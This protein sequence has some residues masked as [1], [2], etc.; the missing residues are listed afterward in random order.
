M[1]AL[2]LGSI[3][4][5]SINV[6]NLEQ[7]LAFYELSLG[8]SRLARP[9]LSVE[10]AWLAVGSSELHLIVAVGSTPAAGQH[11]AFGVVDLDATRSSLIEAGIQVSNPTSLGNGASQAFF[12]D[13]DGNLLEINQ[14]AP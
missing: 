12:S 13:P 1:T 8:L 9:D 10:G 6:S 3:Q 14:P 4:H 11:F 5:V 2:D 7:S